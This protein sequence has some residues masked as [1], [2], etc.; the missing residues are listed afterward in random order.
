MEGGHH[1]RR[2]DSITRFSCLRASSR[3]CYRLITSEIARQGGCAIVHND[4]LE[5]CGS[6]RVYRPALSELHALGLLEVERYPEA[7]SLPA[8]GSLARDDRA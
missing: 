1:G 4:V 6:R 8:V 5:L 2:E 3:R 7:V